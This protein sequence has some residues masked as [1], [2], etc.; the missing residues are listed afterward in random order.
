MYECN[1]MSFII[2]K[3]GGLSVTGTQNVLDIKPESIH[4]RVPCFMGSKLDVEDVLE[5]YR[6]YSS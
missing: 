5:F 4:Q 6:K 2:E 1:P 3:A